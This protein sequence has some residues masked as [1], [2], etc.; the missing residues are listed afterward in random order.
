MLLAQQVG[1]IG[2]HRYRDRKPILFTN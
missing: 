1:N 2:T